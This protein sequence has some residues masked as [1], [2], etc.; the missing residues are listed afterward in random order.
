MLNNCT[1]GLRSAD[2][3]ATYVK[4]C[5]RT[6]FG[7]CGFRSAGPAVWN[8]LPDELRRRPIVVIRLYIVALLW[9]TSSIALPARR[10]TLFTGQVV[11]LWRGFLTVLLGR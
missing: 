1:P 6:N 4:P 7:D 2:T 10:M 11:C 8:S 9:K 3:L 5:T